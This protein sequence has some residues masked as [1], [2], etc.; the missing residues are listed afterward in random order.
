M[1]TTKG[2]GAFKKK[3]IMS[4]QSAKTHTLTG[5]VAWRNR[6]LKKAIAMEKL[7]MKEKFEQKNEI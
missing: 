2:F 5:L 7:G 3:N 4:Y 1:I 6:K